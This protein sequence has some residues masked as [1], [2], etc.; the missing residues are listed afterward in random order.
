MILIILLYIFI[1]K[2][3][4]LFCCLEDIFIYSFVLGLFMVIYKVFL[5]IL[6]RLGILLYGIC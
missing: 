5:Y 1:F 6:R 3:I 2:M 4:F